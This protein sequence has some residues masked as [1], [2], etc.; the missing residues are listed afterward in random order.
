[1]RQILII[2]RDRIKYQA[3]R[4]KLEGMLAVEIIW[5]NDSDSAISLLSILPELEFILIGDSPKNQEA[6]KK[7]EDFITQES[8]LIPLLVLSKDQKNRAK[9]ININDDLDSDY[10]LEFVK[11]QF[12]K[13]D[14]LKNTKAIPLFV[15]I[16]TNFLA[17]YKDTAFPVDFYLRIKQSA[18]EFQ[19]IKR[20]HANDIFSDSEREQLEKHKIS[21]LYIL[22]NDY[23]SFL[24]FSLK[25]SSQRKKDEPNEIIKSSFD[26][27]LTRE[28]LNLVGIDEETQKIVESNISSMEKIVA[29]NESIVNFLTMLQQNPGSYS[30]V[31]SVL[32]AMI[33]TKV[34]SQFDWNSRL[35]KEKICF[36]AFFHDI[37]IPDD[38]LA[39]ISTNDELL[40]EVTKDFEFEPDSKIKNKKYNNHEIEQV[41]NHALNSA[42]LIEQFDNIPPGI[43]LLIKEHHGSKN[44]IGFCENLSITLQPLSILF[45]IVE[46]FVGEFL[47][48]ERPTKEDLNKIVDA[49]AS[50]YNKGSYKKVVDALVKTVK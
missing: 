5:A 46:N 13:N 38:K 11:E 2:D 41:Q 17:Q 21:Q 47:K 33:S 43:S 14:T 35:I 40:E 9:A 31:H 16:S 18:E 25:L 6:I 20:L 27:H 7:I 3:F 37:S 42:I 26:Y 30:Y 45:L 12:V 10:F 50:K 36:V 32:L 29:K 48:V 4:A 23:K 34:V 28:S 8:S 24:E 49:L 19:Y 39:K 44:G 15:A 1:M 22:K